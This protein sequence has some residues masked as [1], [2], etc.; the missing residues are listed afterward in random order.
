MPCSATH[1]CTMSSPVLPSTVA[2]VRRRQ[3]RVDLGSHVQGSPCG[4]SSSL[5][6]PPAPR[7][8]R[9]RRRAGGAV[10]CRGRHGT[11]PSARCSLTI[12]TTTTTITT[13][14][15]RFRLMAAGRQPPAVPAFGMARDETHPASARVARVE[16]TAAHVPDFVAVTK[17]HPSLP[18]PTRRSDT[19][20]VRMNQRAGRR[21]ASR[22]AGQPAQVCNDEE[23]AA[24]TRWGRASG[25]SEPRA[26]GAPAR[27]RPPSIRRRVPRGAARWSR[28]RHQICPQRPRHSKTPATGRPPRSL[29]GRRPRTIHSR[30]MDHHA[31]RR[32]AFGACHYCIFISPLCAAGSACHPAGG[33]EAASLDRPGTRYH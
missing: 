17:S 8:W 20:T 6:F 28:F 15:V 3:D 27:S 26:L 14:R 2:H 24:N 18:I 13:H 22:P 29:S 9:R 21:S 10:R 12:T 1:A 7:R 19:A 16:S 33:L 32:R 23:R 5:L 4:P 11:A 30:V 25:P 31:S